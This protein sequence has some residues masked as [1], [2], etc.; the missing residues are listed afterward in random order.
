L[1]NDAKSL[2]NVPEIAKIED[3]LPLRIADV[4]LI[5]DDMRVTVVKNLSDI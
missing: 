4:R 1:G 3:L 5:G 2:L